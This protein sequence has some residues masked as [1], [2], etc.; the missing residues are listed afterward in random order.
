VPATRTS[1]NAASKA[2]P[3]KAIKK[4]IERS[5]GFQNSVVKVPRGSEQALII[6]SKKA[7]KT[8]DSTSISFL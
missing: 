6:P 4:A 7:V 1:V 8:I 2:P 3:P 5:D